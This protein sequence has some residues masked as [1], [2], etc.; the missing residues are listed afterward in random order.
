MRAFEIN[1][2]FGLQHLKLAER[3]RPRPEPGQVLVRLKAVTL[4]YRDLLLVEGRYNPRLRLPIVPVSDGAGIV[5]E[6][7]TGVTRFRPGDRVVTVLFQGWI[8]GEPT[9]A[10]LATGLGAGLDGVLCEY[11]VLDEASN[12]AVITLVSS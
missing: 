11:R 7:G 8:E 5:E 4:N 10:K 1:G 12:T 9:A 2:G 6:V 3:P